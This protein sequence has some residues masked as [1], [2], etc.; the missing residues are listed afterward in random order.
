MNGE[1]IVKVF[2][3]CVLVFMVLAPGGPERIA[4]VV[5]AFLG[6]AHT[7]AVQLLHQLDFGSTADS[8]HTTTTTAR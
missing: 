3:L 1:R 6:A 7:V 5:S 8:V 2:L 4:A